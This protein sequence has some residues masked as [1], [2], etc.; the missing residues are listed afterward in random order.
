M[1][2]LSENL[3]C[4]P[5]I[6]E[7]VFVEPAAVDGEKS[8]TSELQE[9]DSKTETDDSKTEDTSNNGILYH[10]CTCDNSRS[11]LSYENTEFAF[12]ISCAR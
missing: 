3:L 9:T 11:V 8:H 7:V 12:T 10:I 4:F 1:A 5:V 6:K 2:K